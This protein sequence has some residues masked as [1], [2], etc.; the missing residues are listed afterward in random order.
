MMLK[1]LIQGD[2]QSY[3]GD[4]MLHKTTAPAGFEATILKGYIYL[5]LRVRSRS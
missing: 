2:G 5:E 3:Q 4:I 1:I